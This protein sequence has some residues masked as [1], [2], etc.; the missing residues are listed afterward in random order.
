MHLTSGCV[1]VFLGL[2]A[3]RPRGAAIATRTRTPCS[4]QPPRGLP[5]WGDDQI[6]RASIWSSSDG[7]QPRRDGEGAFRWRAGCD[8]RPM[9]ASPIA[10]KGG[11]R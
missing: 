8:C 11:P 6:G 5:T 4:T 2:H 7:D 10:T 1:E 9:G 3:A